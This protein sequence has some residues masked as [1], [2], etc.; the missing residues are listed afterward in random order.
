MTKWTGTS[1]TSLEAIHFRSGKRLSLKVQGGNIVDL[2]V[3]ENSADTDLPYVGPG[4][5]DLQVNGYMGIDFNQPPIDEEDIVRAI[6]FL[7][8]EGVTS[9]LPTIIT[10]S[11]DNI[12]IAVRNIADARAND[13]LVAKSIPGIHLEGPF[14]SPEDGPRGAH[15]KAH[16]K[17]PDW[18]LFAQWQEVAEGAIKVV[19]LSPEWIGSTD[20]IERC[21]KSG[22]VVAIGH[23]SATPE[24]VREA[25]V[26]GATLSTH[27][28]NG[29]HQLLPR[30]SNYVWE[31]LAEDGLWASIIADG[32]HLPESVLKVVF[33]VKGPKTILVSDAVSL[34]GME[35]GEYYTHVGGRVILTPDGRLHLAHNPQLLAGSVRMLREGVG[36]MVRT[37]LS[38]LPDAWE[39][40]SVRPA[41]L[42]HDDRNNGLTVGAPADFVLFEHLEGDIEILRTYKAGALVFDARKEQ[43]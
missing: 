7:W 32:F 12:E 8:Q 13:D 43:K 16:V 27:L 37:R 29:T 28:G 24:Q 22:V 19:T 15:D 34:S 11:D 40:A 17:P 10:N 20:F 9:F 31:Q 6:Q 39:M 38:S 18:S 30:H 35:P 3:R 23:T 4:L 26:S 42:L 36:H 14:I 33:R 2:Q 21:V 41:S 1:S 5:H 25:V